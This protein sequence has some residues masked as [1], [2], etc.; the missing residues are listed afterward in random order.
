[1]LV[2]NL[3][4]HYHTSRL[5]WQIVSIFVGIMLDRSFIYL[6]LDSNERGAVMAK[7]FQSRRAV[8][9]MAKDCLLGDKKPT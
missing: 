7:M 3:G 2:R 9:L 4:G 1:M 6:Q 5:G 8:H